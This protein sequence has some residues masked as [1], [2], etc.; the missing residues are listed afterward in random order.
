MQA[1]KLSLNLILI[2]VDLVWNF[3]V[4]YKF[5]NLNPHLFNHILCVFKILNLFKWSIK[6]SFKIKLQLAIDN[7]DV[8]FI[9]L[10]CYVNITVVMYLWYKQ[11]HCNHLQQ[12]NKWYCN[13]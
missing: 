7:T 2:C 12:R 8:L 9:N 1:N 10:K 11:M 4:F 6:M 3:N 13:R 5:V